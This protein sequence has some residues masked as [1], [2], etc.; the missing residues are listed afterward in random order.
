MA[1]FRILWQFNFSLGILARE[2]V[3]EFE[4]NPSNTLAARISEKSG[5]V[6]VPNETKDN[7]SDAAEKGANQKN[8]KRRDKA[9]KR[10]LL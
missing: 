10:L 3:V 6:L 7:S 4:S 2:D 5:L 1:R 8:T 9:H